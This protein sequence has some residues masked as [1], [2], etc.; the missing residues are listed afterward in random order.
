MLGYGIKMA[1]KKYI[2]VRLFFVHLM[3][4]ICAFP[5]EVIRLALDIH[6]E[7]TCEDRFNVSKS[8]RLSFNYMEIC[9]LV[10]D[11]GKIIENKTYDSIVQKQFLL[12]FE[13]KKEFLEFLLMK[14]CK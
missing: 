8:K 7:L 11:I 10:D 13:E 4:E 14:T 12:L 6:R 9:K 3:L 1:G 2:F 5:D